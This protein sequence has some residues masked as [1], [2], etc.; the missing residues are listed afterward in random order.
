MNRLILIGNGFD[1]AHGL[2]TDYNSF[3][4]WYLT[5]CFSD[6]QIN[7]SYDDELIEIRSL[8]PGPEFRIGH[9]SS[10]SQLI[11]YYYENGLGILF[12]ND[13][14]R[15]PDSGNIYDNPFKIKIKSNLLRTLISSCQSSNWVDIENEF[16][17]ELK[18]ILSERGSQKINLLKDLNG[19]LAAIIRNL[20]QYLS[21]I[22]PTSICHGYQ[23]IFESEFIFSD[24]VGKLS[25]SRYD[26]LPQKSVILNFNYTRTIEKYFESDSGIKP[27]EINYIHGVIE[28]IENPIIFGFGDELDADYNKIEL[29]KINAFF[30]YIKSFWYFKTSNYHK[31]IRFIEANEFQVYILGHSCGLSD[32]TMLNMIFE[33]NNCKSIKIYYY[34]NPQGNNFEN[35][36]QEISRHFKDK[37]AMRR[38]IIPFDKS[39]PMPQIIS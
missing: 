33:H 27:I 9:I 31:L 1:L 34:Q 19:S 29:E 3:I 30:K 2:K 7:T 20:E 18:N 38:K 14:F 22:M 8:L 32:R 25:T 10:V 17:N 35:L 37:A 5:E 28:D 21:L 15:F 11:E 6:A 39:Q 16:Y 4:V 13:E 23:K 12:Y 24:F 36:T 26:V